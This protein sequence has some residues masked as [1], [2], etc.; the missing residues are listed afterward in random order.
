MSQETEYIYRINKAVS[1]IEQNLDQQIDLALL[2][3]K[4]FYSPFHFHRVFST[5]VKE[6]PAQFINRLRI[7]AIASQLLKLEDNSLSDL[8]MKYGFQNLSSFSRAFKKH[9][10]M[11]A[12]EFGNLNM[13]T[14]SK[15]RKTESKN[16]QPEIRVEHYFWNIKQ[17]KDWMVM[18]TKIE[19]KQMPEFHL[20]SMRHVGEFDQIGPVYE[21]LFRWAG[22]K[23]LLGNPNFKTATVYHDDPSVTDVSKLRQSAGIT[24]ENMI[25]AEGE[26]LPLL[27]AAGK[28]AVGRFEIT[29]LEFEKAWNSMCVWVEESGEKENDNDGQYYELYHNDHTQHPERK[30]ILDI[31]IPLK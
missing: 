16:G 14:F 12:T 11:S 29:E 24:V 2:A 5:L 7:E 17:I 19:V 21:K 25:Q 9:Y 26:I 28:Y 15:I 8:S 18:N 1:F 10:G 27:I 22:P 31:C 30:F 23:G 13:E 3:K 20:A 4:A 6:T